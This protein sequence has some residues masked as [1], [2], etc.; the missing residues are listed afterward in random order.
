LEIGTG[1]EDIAINISSKAKKV[2][3]C[4]LSPDMIK[5]LQCALKSPLAV[6]TKNKAIIQYT[7]R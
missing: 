4:D 2:I 3:A 5:H 7:E 1:I 6:Q